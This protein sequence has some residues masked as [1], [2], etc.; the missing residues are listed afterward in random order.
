[1]TG[2][3][4]SPGR[5]T[6]SG[7]T[8]ETFIV[9]ILGSHE[10]QVGVGALVG[11]REIITCAH[12][13][14][15]ALGLDARAQ[16]QPADIVT[17]DF[18]LLPGAG[19]EGGQHRRV[20]VVERWLAPPREG[21][22]GGDLAGLV[23][24]DGP[25][26]GGA[27]PVKLA[28][29]QPERGTKAYVFGYP[30]RRPAG[31]WVPT[32]F[33]G[34]V[35]GG[36][37]QLNSGSEAALQVQPG[38][39]GSPVYDGA[40]G[41]IIGLIALAGQ[42][43]AAGRDSYAIAYDEIR[44]M[45]P[46]ILDPGS[47]HA[48]ARTRGVRTRRPASAPDSRSTPRRYSR[49]RAVRISA[50]TTALLA[51][52][53][54]TTAAV[55][56][57]WI[58]HTPDSHVV[59]LHSKTPQPVTTKTSRPPGPPSIL[60]PAP[61]VVLLKKSTHI[62]EAIAFSTDGIIAIATTVQS[63][64]SGYTYLRNSAGHDI[65]PPLKDYEGQGAQAVA[66]SH[67]GTILA[68]GDANGSV[69]LWNVPKGT[70]IK[71]LREPGS[72]GGQAGS[73]LDGRQGVLAVAFS[74]R[75]DLIA[76]GDANGSINLWS[77][78]NGYPYDGALTDHDGSGAQALAFGPDDTLAVGDFEGSTYLWDTDSRTLDATLPDGGSGDVQALAFWSPSNGSGL[79]GSG[80]NGSGLNGS[81]LNGS[82][83]TLA[84]GK[85]YIGTLAA[86]D[87]DGK[88][89]LWQITL[90]ASSGLVGGTLIHVLPDPGE[91]GVE[92]VAFSPDGATLATG[93]QDHSAYLWRLSKFEI[94]A[95][96]HVANEYYGVDSVAFSSSGTTLA[97]GDHVGGAYSWLLTKAML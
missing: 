68:V 87:A 82:G 48:K 15:R 81:G 3:N 70:F 19:A 59:A 80:L 66:F 58:W 96:L 76:A 30:S 40:S 65:V 16:A 55:S 63:G 73:N 57:D 46:E 79:N 93:D 83:G 25:V 51:A 89:Y 1:V 86:G 23:L 94:T 20:A 21:A 69:Y 22:G 90:G 33:Q 91:Q 75:G 4:T 53:A 5:K 56:R 42:G 8:E 64:G 27:I 12:V 72:Q 17:V 7:L 34:R 2:V 10:E 31:A 13:V 45:W 18:P 77:T 44:A 9:R 60:Q 36:F 37:L 49:R 43:T 24:T 62:P 88:T 97:A 39:S 61:S 26:P 92:A 35:G 50:L 85:T 14:N 28:V 84:G 78:G 29:K 67:K 41:T 6:A 52:A 95:R 71:R 74:T 11:L 32:H 38:F 54:L 47:A